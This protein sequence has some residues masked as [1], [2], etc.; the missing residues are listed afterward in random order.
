MTGKPLLNFPA[1]NAEADRL[2]A[3]GYDVVNPAEIN[4]DHS[5][6][7]ATCMRDDIAQLVRCEGI[8]L[9]PGWENSKGASLEHHIA[10]ELGMNVTY[11]GQIQRRCA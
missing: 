3:L 9:L 5:V 11:A 1:F 7:W 6:P 10:F 8:V 4:P 2:R